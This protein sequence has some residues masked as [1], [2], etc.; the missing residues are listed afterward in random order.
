MG[1]E[2]AHLHPASVHSALNP[3]NQLEEGD[4]TEGGSYASW[5]M[6]NHCNSSRHLVWWAHVLSID[7][8]WQVR[9]LQEQP[10]HYVAGKGLNGCPLKLCWSLST[11]HGGEGAALESS[12]PESLKESSWEFLGLE[13]HEPTMNTPIF[14]GALS[15]ESVTPRT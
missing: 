3:N 1:K 11:L 8:H 2:S 13:R 6:L 7:I 15:E 10:R 12:S 5:I 14:E 4:W 9:N